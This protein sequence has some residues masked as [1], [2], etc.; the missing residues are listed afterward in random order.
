MWEGYP[1]SKKLAFLANTGQACCQC[2]WGLGSD[3]TILRLAKGQLITHLLNI[4]CY[5]VNRT[6]Q[7]KLAE[8]NHYYQSPTSDTRISHLCFSRPQP[9]LVNTHWS[10]V[11]RFTSVSVFHVSAFKEI[12][13][14]KLYTECLRHSPYTSIQYLWFH[15]LKNTGSYSFRNTLH[16]P[17]TVVCQNA[18]CPPSIATYGSKAAAVDTSLL[19]TLLP[20]RDHGKYV[21]LSR[22]LVSKHWKDFLYFILHYLKHETQEIGGTQP[23]GFVSQFRVQN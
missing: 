18:Q 1:V 19:Q 17:P 23:T 6:W 8:Q 10:S 2:I 5:C 4:L 15:H 13:Q 16:C 20:D 9:C 22:H 12:S 3:V 14:S 21:H 11:F 7:K